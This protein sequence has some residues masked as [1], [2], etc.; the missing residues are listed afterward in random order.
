MLILPTGIGIT[1]AFRVLMMLLERAV[2]WVTVLL[3]IG[4]GGAC[5]SRG[6]S[7]CGGLLAKGRLM[8]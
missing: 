6:Y 3:S 1:C 8:G 2:C 5:V 4:T 7:S